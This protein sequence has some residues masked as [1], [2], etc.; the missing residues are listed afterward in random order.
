MNVAFIGL[1]AIGLPMAL[2]I[3]KAGHGVVG[4]ELSEAGGLVPR[5]KVLK[6]ALIGAS[7]WMPTWWW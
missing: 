2:Q 7:C 1:G 6:P 4:V 3:Q 5:P